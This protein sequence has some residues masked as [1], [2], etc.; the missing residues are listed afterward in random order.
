[1]D[2]DFPQKST[3]SLQYTEEENGSGY[4]Y[5]TVDA[6]FDR[7]EDCDDNSNK[8]YYDLQW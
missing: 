1:M 6:V 5:R 3:S 4:G 2:P 8:E 7:R